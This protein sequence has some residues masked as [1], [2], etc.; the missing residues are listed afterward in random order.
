MPLI[1]ETPESSLSAF[2]MWEHSKKK[3]GYKP[4]S[5]LSPDTESA[6]PLI[7]DLPASWTLRKACLLFNFPDWYVCY[8]S[9]NRLRHMLTKWMNSA[10]TL[11]L[12]FLHSAG[13]TTVLI[14]LVWAFWFSPP[15]KTSL[16]SHFIGHYPSLIQSWQ[17]TEKTARL[18]QHSQ[19][20]H[21]HSPSPCW[22]MMLPL[23]VDREDRHRWVQCT[24]DLGENSAQLLASL[25]HP[26]WSWA[27]IQKQRGDR[28]ILK[29]QLVEV[30]LKLREWWEILADRNIIRQKNFRL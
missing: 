7:L 11:S 25:L 12:C 21:K 17:K 9:Q 10:N 27:D 8:S 15:P 16:S 13:A 18:S 19:V 20:S 22:E 24:G 6:G 26:M 1:E 14:S 3:T 4:G 28:E 23:V 5:G 29:H 30:D 2:T